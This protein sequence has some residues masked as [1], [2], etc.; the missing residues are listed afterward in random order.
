MIWNSIE[1]FNWIKKNFQIWFFENESFYGKRNKTPIH[2]I[3]QW[4]YGKFPSKCFY[5]EIKNKCGSLKINI[6]EL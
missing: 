1:K 3:L 2:S 6:F 4:N 5:N